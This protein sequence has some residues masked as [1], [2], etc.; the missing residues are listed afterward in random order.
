M[1]RPEAPPKKAPPEPSPERSDARAIVAL[2]GP[3][4]FT[5]PALALAQRDWSFFGIPTLV[6]YVFAAWLLG[7][8]LTRAVNRRMRD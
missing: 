8:V 3:L 1:N 6:V 5:P 4:L 2:A 7:I